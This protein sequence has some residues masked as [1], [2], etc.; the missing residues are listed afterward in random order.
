MK[1]D[2]VVIYDCSHTG[3]EIYHQVDDCENEKEAEI[4]FLEEN[5]TN[6]GYTIERLSNDR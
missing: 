6:S 3:K 1:G 2:Y 5:I 4:K